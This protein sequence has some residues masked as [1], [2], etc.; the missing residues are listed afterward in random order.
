MTESGSQSIL[1]VEPVWGQDTSPGLR[2][3]EGVHLGRFQVEQLLGTG[4]MAE[5]W[6]AADPV[7]QGPVVIKLLSPFLR[8]NTDE[9]QRLD[10]SFRKVQGLQH[11]HI[12]PLY[13]LVNDP[14]LGSYLVM[15]FVEGATLSM[16]RWRFLQTN[17]AFFMSEIVRLLRPIAEALDY[18][19][20]QGIAHRDVK[21]AN[22]V[23]ASDGSGPQ[24][25]DFGLAAEIRGCVSR[26]TNLNQDI[27]GTKL[28]MPPEQWRGWLQ[29]GRADQYSLA[30]VAYEL[31]SGLPPFATV[32]DPD[33]LRQCVLQ[34]SI[35]ELTEA[36]EP[37]NRVLLKAL[38]KEPADRFE[39][40]V[41]FIE[42]LAVADGVAS[43]AS[44]RISL[45]P[46]MA[47]TKRSANGLVKLTM[48]AAIA[49]LAVAIGTPQG[50]RVRADL[51]QWMSH[52]LRSS[53]ESMTLT[54]ASQPIAHGDP[55]AA[56]VP[57][58]PPTQEALEPVPNKSPSPLVITKVSLEKP[59]KPEK[60]PQDTS[61]E[62]MTK[63][64]STEQSRLEAHQDRRLAETA[65]ATSA[66]AEFPTG[67]AILFQADKAADQERYDDAQALYTSARKQ[68]AE[69]QVKAT[70]RIQ[71]ENQQA[72]DIEFQ[73]SLATQARD[74]A[75]R[76]K[77]ES[78]AK[79]AW[80]EGQKSFDQGVSGVRER[81]FS[82]AKQC[83]RQAQDSFRKAHLETDQWQAAQVAQRSLESE[84]S[85]LDAKEVERLGGDDW[86]TINSDIADAKQ[87]QDPVWIKRAC[88]RGRSLLPVIR[89]K[90]A[91][92]KTQTQTV[93]KPVPEQDA[94][95]MDVPAVCSQCG[96][97]H[98][99]QKAWVKRCAT[100]G[101][102]HQ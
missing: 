13:D 27:S 86:R 72:A 78:L 15:K 43:P 14:D 36:S 69:A 41:A 6:K 29:D 19:H 50:V 95:W 52:L 66:D 12:C 71:E 56:V 17:A 26:V 20:S 18:A 9:L 87:A 83:F 79:N 74:E 85:S 16:Y 67:L 99:T 101:K 37:V 97:A 32:T 53:S 92:S 91:A 73:K 47:K 40:C 23:V 68:F 62:S 49:L 70:R 90:I 51:A 58:A 63:K 3:R 77:A 46:V 80:N 59:A 88:D 42:A 102:Y 75:A 84:L 57:E 30:I 4:G 10:D 98:L 38:S 60:P 48:W 54:E 81:N 25:V 93:H 2:L 5:V 34:E 31:L 94:Q 33:V 44:R 55:P 7:R 96:R 28:Y 8:G 35:P 82:L 76:K 24:L 65:G 61:V 22:I 64:S 100:C 39:S 21:P 89:G 45:S 11:Q 1:T